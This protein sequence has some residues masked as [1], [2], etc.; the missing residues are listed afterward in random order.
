MNAQFQLYSEL[1]AQ[2]A[3]VADEWHRVALGAWRRLQEV[4]PELAKLA[5]S[6]FVSEDAAADWLARPQAGMTC[7]AKLASG[8]REDVCNQLTAGSYGIFA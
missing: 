1:D 3:M 6:V 8:G 7:Y 4:D 5:I 2:L